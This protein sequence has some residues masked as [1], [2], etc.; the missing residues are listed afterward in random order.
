MLNNRQ[1]LK[2]KQDGLVLLLLV[3]VLALT[4]SSYYFSSI[5]I[6]NIKLESNLNTQTELQRAKQAL[7]D[8]AVIHW[9][10]AGEGGKIGKL[11]CPDTMNL[12]E[13]SQNAPC[14]N[15]Y[16]NALGFFPWRTL[17][18]DVPKDSSGSCF[19]Y[20]VSP[21]YK[22]TPLVA[23][24]QDSYGQI[25]IVNSADDI[26]QGSTPEDR[27]VAAIIA[28][29]RAL[30]LPLPGQIRTFDVDS[31]CG[32]DYG[33][34]PAYLDNDG[35]TNNAAPRLDG[36]IN[37]L[38]SRYLGSEDTITP[39]NDRIITIT[40]K[41]LWSALESSINSP[42]FG[43]RMEQLTEAVAMCLAAYGSNNADHLPMPAP[44]DINGNEYRNNFDYD[45]AAVFTTGFSGR[46]P[47]VIG[48][49]NAELT[50]P[51]IPTPPSVAGNH[52]ELFKNIVCNDIDL[53]TG[54]YDNINFNVATGDDE[55]EFLNLLRNWQDHFFYA[56][57]AANKPDSTS[58]T[59]TGNCIS[60]ATTAAEYAGIVF[61]SGLKQAGQQRYTRP[62]DQP[63]AGDG[64]DKNEVANYLENG[65]AA[66]FPDDIGNQ[67]YSNVTAGNDIMFC[68]T[69]AMTVEPC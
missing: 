1:K 67:V 19:L 47:Y 49:A 27:P 14:G 5:S 43:T 59:C 54:S 13:G 26:V 40:H 32:L 42:A 23:L 69:P 3:V 56:I 21:G 16:N 7:L 48:G 12:P 44:L 62:F 57:S 17:N 38:L 34:I 37:Q 4:L 33:N 18:I 51:T 35:G 25:Q 60:I 6:Q 65:N 31:F 41:E 22:V 8:Y 9:Q 11:P 58:T 46:L 63:L 68:I 53:I 2:K 61:F 24:N 55:G 28:P 64:D 20:M 10:T 29:G 39:L 15:A 52:N 30:S 50:M 66:L 45:D 36:E